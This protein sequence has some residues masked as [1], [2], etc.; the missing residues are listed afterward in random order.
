MTTIFFFNLQYPKLFDGIDIHICGNNGWQ[1]F[2]LENLKKL[3]TEFGAKLIK[4]MP[5]PED[6]STNIMPYHSR[7]SK[8]MDHV[9]TIILYTKESDRLIKYNMEH[10][11]AFHI[12]WFMEAAQKFIIE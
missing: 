9:S 11:K 8:H 3:V 10:I 4:R 1:E 6:C 5:N 12:S 7:S 2:S